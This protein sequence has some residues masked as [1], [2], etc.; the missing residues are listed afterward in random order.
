MAD[1]LCSPRDCYESENRRKGED[2]QSPW[3]ITQLFT[4]LPSKALNLVLQKTPMEHLS[5]TCYQGPLFWLRSALPSISQGL[6]PH[7]TNKQLKWASLN[8]TWF[9]GAFPL[10]AIKVSHAG[11]VQTNTG[12]IKMVVDVSCDSC[13]SASLILHR[14]SGVHLGWLLGTKT[15]SQPRTAVDGGAWALGFEIAVPWI[16]GVHLRSWDFVWPNVKLIASSLIFIKYQISR[17]IV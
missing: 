13:P 9:K 7:T 6:R 16:S 2:K 4:H 17:T 11:R 3:I 12:F 1:F 8:S 14:T 5:L 10:K 15:K